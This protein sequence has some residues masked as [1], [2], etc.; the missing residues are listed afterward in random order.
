MQGPGAFG[1]AVVAA[2]ALVA[3][4]C[5]DSARQPHCDGAVGICVD[6]IPH[7]AAGDGNLPRTDSG[8]VVGCS[9]L[10]SNGVCAGQQSCFPDQALSG[11]TGCAVAGTM[12]DRFPCQ[13]QTDCVA[14]EICVDLSG[15]GQV[16]LQL[17]RSDVNLPAANC[18]DALSTIC[19]ALRNYPGVGYCR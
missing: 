9:L 4:A 3:A 15:T 16:C 17:C 11:A 5:V 18:L 6:P 10:E 12:F 8:V 19:V 14:G 7:D 13:L 1:W 2:A